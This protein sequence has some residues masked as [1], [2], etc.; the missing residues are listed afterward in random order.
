VRIEI[1]GE[2]PFIAAHCV[3]ATLACSRRGE[4]GDGSMWRQSECV[5]ALEGWEFCPCIGVGVVRWTRR[6]ALDKDT[7]QAIV[8]KHTVPMYREAR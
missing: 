3:K 4:G 1:T 6:V 2:V 5:L 8:R 7:W